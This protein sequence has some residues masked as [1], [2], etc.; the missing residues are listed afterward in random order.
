MGG[1]EKVIYECQQKKKT[2]LMFWF[3]WFL[4]EYK[5]QHFVTEKGN[6]LMLKKEKLD[7]KQKKLS[8]VSPHNFSKT[9]RHVENIKWVLCTYFS[10]QSIQF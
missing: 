3:E 4:L 8:A 1:W 6:F 7:E 9:A 2:Q 10:C 5:N